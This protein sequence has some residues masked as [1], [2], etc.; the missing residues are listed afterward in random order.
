MLSHTGQLERD[1]MAM[2]VMNLLKTILVAAMALVS[3]KLSSLS[4][5]HGVA[6]RLQ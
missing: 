2:E 4:H 3:G 1:I 5:Q 6:Y